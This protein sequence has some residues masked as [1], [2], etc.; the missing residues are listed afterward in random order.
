MKGW[1]KD[2]YRHYLAAK[3]IK[4]KKYYSKMFRE[5][6]LPKRGVHI[7][8]TPRNRKIAAKIIQKNPEL[9]KLKGKKDTALVIDEFKTPGLF[10]VVEGEKIVGIDTSLFKSNRPKAE[11]DIAREAVAKVYGLDVNDSKVHKIAT[12]LMNKK[13]THKTRM[14]DSSLSGTM[15]HEFT[16]AGQVER[17]D[18]YDDMVEDYG[19]LGQMYDVAGKS[20]QEGSIERENQLKMH[21]KHKQHKLEKEAYKQG[22][23]F[24]V[25][26]SEREE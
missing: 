7:I 5:E 11:Y 20:F 18:S 22:D 17:Y 23:I 4:T 19:E 9:I 12:E 25:K 15:A 26:R 16:H 1:H 8:G 14:E 10:R 2:S 3:G 24:K 6:Y 21:K 13:G